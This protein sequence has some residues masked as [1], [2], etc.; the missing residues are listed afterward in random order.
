VD[1][2]TGPTQRERPGRVHRD[3][4]LLRPVDHP[5]KGNGGL[6]YEAG[7]RG[8]KGMLVTFQKAAGSIDPRDRGAVRR[9][10]A[11]GARLHAAL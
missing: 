2:K 4:Y 9:R 7:N 3:F 6:F 1:L 11:D 8:T 10:I 5:A